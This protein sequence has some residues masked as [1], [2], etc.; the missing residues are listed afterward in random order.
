MRHDLHR[1][2]GYLDHREEGEFT[3]GS[4][5]G[6]D[7]PLARTAEVLLIPDQMYPGLNCTVPENHDGY[8][9][10]EIYSPGSGCKPPERSRTAPI[11]W[12][13]E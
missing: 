4:Q 10:P 8:E 5:G 12:R 3:I 7:N 1:R 11:G 9:P 13:Q 2:T 6:A